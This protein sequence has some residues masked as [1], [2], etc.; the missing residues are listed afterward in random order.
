MDYL[1]KRANEASTWGGIAVA[2]AGLGEAF[3]IGESEL[4]STAVGEVGK[5]VAT[6]MP[7]WMGAIMAAGGVLMTL[8]S[9]GD[10]GW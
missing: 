6:G 7:W 1:R 8:K 5:A 3:K 9:D 10:K 2:L 4:L